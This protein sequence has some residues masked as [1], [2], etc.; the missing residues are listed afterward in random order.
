MGGFFGAV[1]RRDVVL[2]VF[3]GTD[4]HSHLGTRNAGMV[5]WGRENGFNREIHSIANSP[6]RTKFEKDLDTFQGTSGIGCISDSDPQPLLVR[7]HL[8]LYAITTVGQINNIEQLVSRFLSDPGHQ[9]M[10]MSSGRVNMTEFVAALINESDSMI[11][12]IRSMQ[13]FIDGSMTILIM[14]DKGEI[15]AARDRFGRL[16]VLV[17]TNR[18]GYCV[19]FE[20]FAYHKLGYGDVYELG[21]GEIVRINAD[22]YETLSPANEKMKIRL[23]LDLLRLPELQLRGKER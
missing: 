23:S 11:D 10:A 20:S 9:F 2:D 8:G 1:S 3:F 22:G 13:Q 21:P 16:P 7:S 17:G 18:D 14:T 12:G 15:I 4:Y 5:I 6:F 19:S